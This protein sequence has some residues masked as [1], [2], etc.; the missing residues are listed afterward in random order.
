M[1]GQPTSDVNVAVADC[2]RV[3]GVLHPGHPLPHHVERPFT[4]LVP[5]LLHDQQH[6]LR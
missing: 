6:L 1:N 4:L 2:E 5:H 3:L